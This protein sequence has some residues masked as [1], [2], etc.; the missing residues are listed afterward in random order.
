MVEFSKSERLGMARAAVELIRAVTWDELP[1]GEAYWSAVYKA[2]RQH[3][4]E[5]VYQEAEAEQRR[6]LA[7]TER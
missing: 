6:P 2:L 3:A 1:E 7:R 5:A 4:G